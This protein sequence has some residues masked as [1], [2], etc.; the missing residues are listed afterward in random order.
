MHFAAELWSKFR[1]VLVYLKTLECLPN[2][3]PVVRHLG[4]DTQNKARHTCSV[5]YARPA[6]AQPR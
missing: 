4:I 5:W 2:F 6:I 1:N 3:L